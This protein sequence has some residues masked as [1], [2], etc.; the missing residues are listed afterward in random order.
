MESQF[1]DAPS[2]V[3]GFNPSAWRFLLADRSNFIFIES[4]AADMKLSEELV[5]R[6]A[7]FG[8]VVDERAVILIDPAQRIDA[9]VRAE[10]FPSRPEHLHLGVKLHALAL[11]PRLTEELPHWHRTPSA[12]E[13]FSSVQFD[14]PLIADPSTTITRILKF[15]AA[16]LTPAQ[17][18]VRMHLKLG[19]AGQYLAAPSIE[20]EP[21]M[22][23]GSA[24]NR[25]PKNAIEKLLGIRKH[26]RESIPMLDAGSWGQLRGTPGTNPTAALSKYKSQG[27]LFSVS[28]GRRDLYPQFQFDQN[29]APL[30]VI[31]EILKLVPQDA[32]GW[33]LLSWFDAGNVLLSGR[34]PRELLREDPEEVKRAA[35]DYYTEDE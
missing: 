29:A 17:S 24:D 12:Y 13:G 21:S 18:G 6:V 10:V 2:P 34:K 3:Q 14:K 33:P 35:A 28:E 26:L 7:T 16:R 11:T 31:A 25:N 5:N 30:F 8:Q 23:P 27:R 15:L 32:R 19:P 20:L 1:D 4:D 9:Y 22:L